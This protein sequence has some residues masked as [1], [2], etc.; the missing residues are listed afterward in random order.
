MFIL[1]KY[2]RSVYR[3]DL[4]FVGEFPVEPA[5]LV[6]RKSLSFIEFFLPLL[7][8]NQFCWFLGSPFHP[9]DLLMGSL[10][11]TTL[12]PGI[13]IYPTLFFFNSALAISGL[14][15]L[16]LNIII[17]LFSFHKTTFCKLV[18]TALN[19]YSS[20]KELFSWKHRVFLSLN[21]LDSSVIVL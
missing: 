21:L 15:L 18:W 12:K 2:I 20:C 16:H 10:A 3:L 1:V 13:V 7:K 14:L 11:S 17:S 4:A 8:I 5:S 19:P 6:K 9:T